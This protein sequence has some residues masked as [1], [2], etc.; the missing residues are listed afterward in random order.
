MTFYNSPT[1]DVLLY[2]GDFLRD[3]DLINLAAANQ[4]LCDPLARLALK[5]A[6]TQVP[7]NTDLKPIAYAIRNGNMQLF[8]HAL[9][10]LNTSYP[11]G[12]HW[13][14]FY[15]MGVGRVLNLA[16]ASNLV[17][18]TLLAHKY[19]LMSSAS[20][21]PAPAAVYAHGFYS[22]SGD[23]GF[24][25]VFVNL[26]NRE[27]V[28]SALRGNRF[29]CV[30]F[31]LE[32]H[33]PLLFP[34]GFQILNDAICYSSATTLD[35]LLNRGAR[36]GADSLHN[37]AHLDLSDTRVFDILVQ[38]GFEVDSRRAA[39]AISRIG[40]A[41][42]PLLAALDYLEPENVEALLRLGASP[43]GIGDSWIRK[44]PIM[45]RFQYNSPH[46]ILALLFS[47]RYDLAPWFAS[48][49][50]GERFLRCLQLLLSYGTSTSIS[51]PNGSVLEILLLRIWQIIYKQALRL[52]TFMLPTRPDHPDDVNQGVQSLLLALNDSLDISPWDQVFQI[53]S[54]TNPIWRE[55]ANQTTGKSRLTKFL[56]D[57]QER[58]RDLPG[59]AELRVHSLFVLPDR[60]GAQVNI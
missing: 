49:Q 5:K 4:D 46:P 35:F 28:L 11:Q 18:L 1:Y 41:S 6:L 52:P 2:I 30:S 22:N 47:S 58:Y 31:L 17:S 36:P 45:A 54:D 7:F 16:A 57:Y 39:L 55:H 26:K 15:S 38:R 10:F 42:T 13:K 40:E 37:I 25:S 59:V 60:Y 24:T 53:F 56:C 14:Q 29:D 21:G 9:D 19:P 51:L 44:T 48:Q 43:N 32:Q 3:E 34:E 12:W 20:Q 50:I 8:S 33:Q 27:L 23:A